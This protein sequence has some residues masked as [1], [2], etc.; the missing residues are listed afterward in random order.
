MS[1][2]DLFP[3]QGNSIAA[4]AWH[5][6]RLSILGQG[7]GVD[8]GFAITRNSATSVTVALGVAINANAKVSVIEATLATIPAATAGYHRYDLVYVDLA[9]G[10]TKRLAGVEAVPTGRGGHTPLNDFLENYTPMP[11]VLVLTYVP[12]FILRVTENGLEDTAFG[13]Y[14]THGIAPIR[15]GQPVNTAN[16]GVTNGNTHDHAGGDGAQ[17]DH[18]GL[19]GLSDDDHTQYIKHSLATAANDFLVASG[20]GAF[21]KKTLEETKFVLGIASTPAHYERSRMWKN[22]DHTSGGGSAA[23]RRSLVTPDYMTVNINNSGYILSSALT[24]DLD[25]AASWDTESVAAAWQANHAYVLDTVAKKVAGSDYLYVCTVAGTSHAN[26]EPTWG[27]TLGGTTSDGGVTWTCEIK[28]SVAAKRAGKQLYAYA[29]VPVSGVVPVILCSAATT[30]PLGYA[31]NTSRKIA[32]FHCECV[33]VGTISSHWLTGYLA[34]DILPRSVMD[35]RHRPGGFSG[36]FIPGMVWAGNTDFDSYNGPKIWVSIYLASGTGASTASANG[37]TISDTR[38]W[39]DFV[40][41]FAAIGCRML[42]DGEFQ[43][44]AA[45]SN[46]ET[47]ITGS[48]DPVTTSGHVDTAGRRMISNIGCEDCCGVMWQ[49]LRDQSYKYTANTWDWYN[50]PGSKGSL[51]NQSGTAGDAD[52]KLLAGGYWGFGANCGSRCRAADSSRWYTNSA[53]GGRFVAGPA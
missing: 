27:T 13:S 21:V 11:P 16:L 18:G 36:A 26:T 53:F 8:S 35:L 17:I 4:M 5:L 37:G 3:T 40:D 49:W 30:F 45:G 38:D 14:A 9:D 25:A 1:V 44:I 15:M 10:V 47:N 23:D 6:Q 2:T 29:C 48:A 51:Y 24:L 32:S 28:P 52:V 42:D 34:G 19:G 33:A 46:E 7:H 22:D 41:D 43:A 12:L 20:S 50:L 31:A 39:M